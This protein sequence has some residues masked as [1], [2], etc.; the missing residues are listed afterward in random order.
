MQNPEKFDEYADRC[1]D[2]GDIDPYDIVESPEKKEQHPGAGRKAKLKLTMA[3][4]LEEE[5]GVWGDLE[6]PF[7]GFK[8][9]S[10]TLR[11]IKKNTP[12]KSQMS[13]GSKDPDA[14]MADEEAAKL[15]TA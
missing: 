15:E 4:A 2:N 12:D 5:E 11:K 7:V 13:N 9:A 3:E 14:E 1:V 6:K 10:M 8:T